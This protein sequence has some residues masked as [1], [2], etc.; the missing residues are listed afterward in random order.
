VVGVDLV[1]VRCR[2]LQVVPAEFGKLGIKQSIHESASPYLP[3]KSR[4]LNKNLVEI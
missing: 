2:G 1:L 3:P 4:I